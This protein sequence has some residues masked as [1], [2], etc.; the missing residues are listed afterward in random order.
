MRGRTKIVI[1]ALVAIV[2]YT[3]FSDDIK[4]AWSDFHVKLPEYAQSKGPP[5]KLEQNVSKEDLSWFYHADQGA[6]TFG[7]PFEWF[8][9]LEQPTIPWLIF[10]AAD[11]FRDQTYLD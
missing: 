3:Y 8:V 5:R 6:R 9:P 10:N 2:G 1:V 11:P 7:I 4:Q